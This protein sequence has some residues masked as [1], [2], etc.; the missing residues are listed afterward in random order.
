MKKSKL[1]AIIKET[2]LGQGMSK[3]ALARDTEQSDIEYKQQQQLKKQQ[4]KQQTLKSLDLFK[5]AGKGD[6]QKL[7]S[8][9]KNQEKGDWDDLKIEID[10]SKNGEFFVVK[11]PGEDLSF[12]FNPETG[13]LQFIVNYK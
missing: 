9:L 7:I 10:Q 13:K 6:I 11:I 5:I 2:I 12:Y 3:D 4:L 1:K 8:V